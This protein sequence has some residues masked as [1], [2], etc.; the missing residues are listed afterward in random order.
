MAYKLGFVLAQ[1]ACIVDPDV[2]LLGGGLTAAADLYLDDLRASYRS[3]SL[4]ACAETEIRCA[5]L[6]GDAGVIGAARY[7]MQSV[8]RDESQRD[9]LD[10]DFGL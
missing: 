10:P 5:T 6:L 7:A 3:C 4:A 8:P 2:I 1:A 9:W